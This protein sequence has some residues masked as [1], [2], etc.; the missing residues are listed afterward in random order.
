LN[1]APIQTKLTTERNWLDLTHKIASAPQSTCCCALTGARW[2]GYLGSTFVDAKLRNARVLFVGANHNGGHTGLLKTPLMARY[3]GDLARWAATSNR[4]AAG[5][6]LLLNSM[7]AAYMGSWPSWG[8]VWR[9]FNYAREQ[10]EI[11]ETAFAFVN[12]A[13]CPDP[14]DLADDFAI[15]ACQ[16]AFPLSELV[17]AIDARVVFLAKGS[18]TG[19]NIV[20]PNELELRELVMPSPGTPVAPGRR[21]VIRYGSGSRGER[22]REHFRVWLPKEAPKILRFLRSP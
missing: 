16:S 22:D 21:L 9:H 20:V 8:A 19:R 11:S 6:A 13:R 4:T 17:E 10:L 1:S 5:D 18:I 14:R 3:N 7:Q 12:L 2:S 15:P